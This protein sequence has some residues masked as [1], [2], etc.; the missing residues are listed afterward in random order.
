VRALR[1]TLDLCRQFS[2]APHMPDKIASLCREAEGL[3]DRDEV[4]EAMVWA[5]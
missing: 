4:H 5:E 2:F 3:L 1:R